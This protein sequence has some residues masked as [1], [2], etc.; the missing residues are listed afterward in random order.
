MNSKKKHPKKDS[1]GRYV[2]DEESLL[3]LS[4]KESIRQKQARL[5][6]DDN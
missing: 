5:K 3:E 1:Y 2:E 4:L 6:K